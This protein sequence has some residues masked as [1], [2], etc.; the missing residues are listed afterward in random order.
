VDD[1]HDWLDLA[2]AARRE[3]VA[4]DTMRR[5]VRRGVYPSRQVRTPRGLAWR[6]RLASPGDATLDHSLD[7]GLPTVDPTVDPTVMPNLAPT[8]DGVGLVELVHLVDRLQRDVVARTEAATL[9]QARA[10]MLAS[11]LEQAQLALAA[12][13]EPTPQERPFLRDSE[14]STVEPIQTPTT[15][16]T[17][18]PWW[19]LWR[20]VME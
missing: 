4:L 3:R 7:E 2:E 13:K 12:P 1:Q 5:R 8:V 11:Q 9:W 17:G 16:R 20:R 15:A 18:R 14:G 10:E 19:A 6:V